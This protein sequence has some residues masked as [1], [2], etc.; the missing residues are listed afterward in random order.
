MKITIIDYGLSN[1]LSVQRAIEKIGKTVRLSQNMD[2]IKNADVL[3]LPG[4]GAFADGMEGLH[5]LGFVEI[6]QQKVKKGTPILGICLGMQ[7]LFDESEEFGLHKGLNL[8]PGRVVR[9]PDRN[10]NGTPLRVPHVGWN[11]LIPSNNNTR[12]DSNFLA[13]TN[14]GDEVYFVHS[15]ECIPAE[16]DNRIADTIYGDWRI[17][18][19][20][21]KEHVYG[22][23]FHPEKSGRVGL[24]FLKQFFDLCADI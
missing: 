19:C 20:A 9:I 3:I 10:K 23:Q 7:L 24:I 12:F 2:D 21:N 8:I 16:P 5:K 15:F 6:I 1:L 17:C 22:V 11:I 13:K 4:V 14:I 18:A